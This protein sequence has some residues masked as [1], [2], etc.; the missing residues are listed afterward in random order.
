MEIPVF[1]FE[2]IVFCLVP[3]HVWKEFGSIF[4]S[5][6]FLQVDFASSWSTLCPP[7]HESLQSF[8]AKLLLNWLVPSL[9]CC[10]VLL[11]YPKTSSAHFLLTLCL[12][13]C[14]FSTA[15]WAL[16]LVCVNGQQTMITGRIISKRRVFLQ[17]I[18][19]GCKSFSFLC[20]PIT[21]SVTWSKQRYCI[22][23]L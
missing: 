12:M 13:R 23:A 16:R 17:Y 18:N 19:L 22:G 14:T 7:E 10:T 21:L 1:H 20:T 8:P 9:Y 4:L 6:S 3:R 15:L 5:P 11:L 2:A